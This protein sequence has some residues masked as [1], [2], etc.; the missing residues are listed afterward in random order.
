VKF[1]TELACHYFNHAQESTKE[2]IINI[3][4]PGEVLEVLARRRFGNCCKM[5]FGGGGLAAA[6][7]IF[8]CR[9]YLC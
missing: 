5:S 4:L 1:S 9:L 8:T 2:K 6:A 7:L 3:I